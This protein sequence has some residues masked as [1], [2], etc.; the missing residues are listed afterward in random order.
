MALSFSRIVNESIPARLSRI[1][2]HSPANPAPMMTNVGDRAGISNEAS[3][4][5]SSDSKSV[6]RAFLGL[7]SAHGKAK[8]GARTGGRPRWNEEGWFHAPERRGAPALEAHRTLV[9]W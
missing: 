4:T 1:A 7:P 3:T 8:S 9:P 2:R 5:A 6:G